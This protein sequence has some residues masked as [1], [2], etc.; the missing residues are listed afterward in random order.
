MLLLLSNFEVGLVYHNIV[1]TIV[2]QNHFKDISFQCEQQ[3]SPKYQ[4]YL[5]YVNGLFIHFDN[6]F[7]TFVLCQLALSY[8]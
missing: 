7:Y 6:N 3:D 4:M 1:T 2:D 8:N 5:H